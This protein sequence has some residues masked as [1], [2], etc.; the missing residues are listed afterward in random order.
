MTK[1]FLHGVMVAGVVLSLTA[2]EKTK[3]QFDFSKKAPDE[4][5]VIKRAPLEMPPDYSIPTPKPGAPRPQEPSATDLARGAILGEEP[6]R[7]SAGVTSTSDGES[8]LLKRTGA[9]NVPANIREVVDQET[10]EIAEDEEL[11][12][13]KLKKMVGQDVEPR[14]KIVDPV[15]ETNRIKANKA[16]GK[17]ITTG[18]TPSIG[19]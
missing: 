8:A 5:A 14:A 11:G 1:L 17:P 6:K 18:K 16:A 15:A 12:I 2:C 9:D 13:D 10:N 19:D 3:E 7:Q 4:F